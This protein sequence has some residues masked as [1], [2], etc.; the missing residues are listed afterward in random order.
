MLHGSHITY[1]GSCSNFPHRLPS[2]ALFT[3]SICFLILFFW[4]VDYAFKQLLA[5]E[6][7]CQWTLCF[8]YEHALINPWLAICIR[9][10][11]QY[12]SMYLNK[13]THSWSDQPIAHSNQTGMGYSGRRSLSLFPSPPSESLLHAFIF[14][15]FYYLF[16]WW[17]PTPQSD[18]LS[19]K[20][21][22]NLHVFI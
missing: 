16:W 20:K 18:C 6:A 10:H 21:I 3:A 19:T 2:L 1:L 22:L 15:F 7:A 11:C 13:H 12:G 17:Y 8:I 5:I 9:Q 4:K 14:L